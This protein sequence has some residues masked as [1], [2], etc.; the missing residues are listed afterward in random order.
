MAI[1]AEQSDRASRYF[2][3]GNSLENIGSAVVEISIQDELYVFVE[4]RKSK[5]IEEDSI[6]STEEV[7]SVNSNTNQYGNSSIENLDRQ[8]VTQDFVFALASL[9]IPI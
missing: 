1:I 7:L 9:A 4:N 6:R 2:F 8:P 3:G 5:F